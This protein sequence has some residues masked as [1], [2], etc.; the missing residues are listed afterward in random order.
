M[1][2]DRADREPAAAEG[3]DRGSG[4]RSRSARRSA[5]ANA[6]SDGD[7]QDAGSRTVGGCTPHSHH[8]HGQERQRCCTESWSGFGPGGRRTSRS[9]TLGSMTT[10]RSGRGRTRGHGARSRPTPMDSPFV[11]DPAQADAADLLGGDAG[12]RRA[13]RQTPLLWDIDRHNRS[14]H[15]GISLL[16]SARGRG[17]GADVVRVLCHYGFVVRGLHRLQVDTLA[18]NSAMIAAAAACGL[19]PRGDPC[20]PL[21]G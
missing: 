13:G 12:R 18:D 1:D 8:R 19:R 2:R 14:A 3:R 5:G 16:P 9:C 21:P 4:W 10:S 7:G 6:A 11:V 15:L 20:G 17:L